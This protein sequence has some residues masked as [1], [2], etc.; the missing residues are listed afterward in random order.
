M[1]SGLRG[2]D[3]RDKRPA[4]R[5]GSVLSRT[6]AD[7]QHGFANTANPSYGSAATDPSHFLSPK[8]YILTTLLLSIHP[9]RRFQDRDDR[10]DDQGL[11]EDQDRLDGVGVVEEQRAQTGADR[12]QV[13]RQ[14]SLLV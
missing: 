13:Q 12:R 7:W 11:G 14:D 6:H 4:G 5:M 1:D 9:S 3:I 8:S 2:N 10:Q